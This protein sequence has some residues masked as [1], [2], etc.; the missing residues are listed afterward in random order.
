MDSFPGALGQILINLINNA[1]LHAFEGRSDGVVRI[2]A[3]ATDAWVEVQV[4]DNGTGMSSELMSQLFQPFFSTKIGR[5]GTG[6][7]MT[8]VENLVKKTMGGSLVVESSLGVGTVMRIRFP[9]TA[10]V[11]QDI[12]IDPII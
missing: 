2:L 5:G 11:N 1:C 8:I 3:H 12:G 9:Q 7:G 10:P 6:L 4:N